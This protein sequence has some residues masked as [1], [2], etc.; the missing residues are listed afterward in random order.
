[1]YIPT[2]NNIQ[3]ALVV[4]YQDVTK[5]ILPTL[6]PHQDG[7][8]SRGGWTSGAFPHSSLREWYFIS[9]AQL[10]EILL[11]RHSFRPFMRELKTE[12]AIFENTCC[13]LTECDSVQVNAVK[14]QPRQHHYVPKLQT[15][16]NSYWIVKWNALENLHEQFS[17]QIGNSARGITHE[18]EY[19]TAIRGAFMGQSIEEM[20]DKG[21]RGS[22]GGLIDAIPWPLQ[23]G[24]THLYKNVFHPC[25]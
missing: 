8:W 25:P 12:M 24:A 21:I 16:N 9:L 5:G 11:H 22:A 23:A 1:M 3:P 6:Q 4:E 15:R 10:K 19:F 14:L 2:F 7:D 17:T 20:F 18:T 13:Q